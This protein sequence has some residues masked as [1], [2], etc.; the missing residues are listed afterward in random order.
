ML[1]STS[2]FLWR[3]GALMAF[4]L[5]MIGVVVPGLPT[6]PFLLLAAWCG[7]KGWPAMEA[8][9]LQHPRYGETILHWRQHRAIPRRA[10][11]AATLMML[12]SS[13]SIFLFPTPVLLRWLLPP[14]LLCVAIWVWSRPDQ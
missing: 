9:L 4:T 11:I 6:V 10:K 7:G 8:W 12:V 5:G 1:K 3:G 13:S 2:L 14:F